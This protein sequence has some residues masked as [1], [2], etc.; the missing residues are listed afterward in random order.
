MQSK[1]FYAPILWCTLIALPAQAATIKEAFALASQIDE[2]VQTAQQLKAQSA[3][4]NAQSMTPEP[5][6]ITISGTNSLNDNLSPSQGSREYEAELGI[7]LWQWGQKDRLLAQLNQVAQV[8]QGQLQLSR[9]EFAGALREAV[10][11]ARLA[12]LAQDSA[13]QK[14]QALEKISQD[15]QRQLKAGEVAP[16]DVNLAHQALLEAQLQLAVSQQQFSESLL[17]FQALAGDIPVP[18]QA[19]TLPL[20][21]DAVVHPQRQALQAQTQLAGAQLAQAQYDI[22]DTPELALSLTRER[23]SPDEPYKNL[24]KISLRIPFGAEG[25]TQ[26]RVTSANAEL[27]SAQ[28]QVQRTERQINTQQQAANAARELTRQQLQMAQ[29]SLQLATQAWQWQQRSYQAG[30]TNLAAFLSAQAN[31]LERGFAVQRAELELGR[32][33]SRYLQTFGVLP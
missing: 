6:S 4:R 8:E 25:R 20:S 32:A 29:H 31:F 27:I 15:L 24:G 10:W 16:L 18:D 26:A 21:L 19:E 28:T 23:G 33:N 11:N 1:R 7:P 14:L 22:R 5:L 3:L 17:Q 30:Q 13:Q 12:K 2:P 9:W